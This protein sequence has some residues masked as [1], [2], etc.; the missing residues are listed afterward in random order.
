LPDQFNNTIPDFSRV[1]YRQGHVQLPSVPVRVVVEPSVQEDI[2]DT[3]RIQ[4]AIDQVASLPLE[5]FGEEGSAFRGAVLLKA[6]TYRVAGALVIHTAGIVLRGEG[7]D[8]AGTIIIATGAI[9]RDFIL[10][11]GQLTSESASV[12]VQEAKART[13]EMMPSNGYKG[14]KKSTHIR[15]GVFVPVGETYLQVESTAGFQVGDPIVVERPGS[16]E[17]INDIG[18]N[19]L[20]PRPD[21]NKASVQWQKGSFTFRFERTIVWIDQNLGVIELDI[22]MVMSFDPKYPPARVFE[23]VY[24]QPVISDVGIEN[25]RLVSAFDPSNAEDESHAWYAIVIDNTTNGWVSDVTTQHFV[26][27]IYAASW[28]RFITIQDCF[29][30]DPVSKPK[31]GGRR[32]Q[33]NL[34]GQMGLVKRCYTNNARHDFITLSRVCGPHE[35]W[36]MGTLYDN[37]ECNTI[38]VR[39]RLWKGTGQGWAG[40]YQVI[41]NCTAKLSKSCFQDAP[42]STNWVIGFKGGQVEV[43]EFRAQSTRLVATENQVEPRSL[44]W[45]QLIARMGG[46]AELKTML[47]ATKDFMGKAAPAGYIAGL[48]RGATGFTTRSDI[49]P[50]REGPTEADIARLQ[51]QAKR[52]AAE[53]GDDDD[54][55]YQDPDNETGLFNTAPYE[56]DDEEA[57]QIYDSIDA[58]LD[59]RRKAR[60]EARE[61]EMQEKLNKE[62]PKIQDQFADLK[63]G[64]NAVT[65]EEWENLPEVGNIAGK[66]RKKA[67]LRERLAPAPDS[68]IPRAQ[69]EMANTLDAQPNGLT[70][71]VPGTMTNFREIGEANKQVLGLRLDRMA[72]SASG[73]TTI[74]PKGYLTDLN[75]VIVKSEAEIGDLKKARLLLKSVITTNPKHAPGWIAAARLEEHAGKLADARQIIDKGCLECPK[76]EDIWLEAARLNNTENAKRILANAVKQ[77]PQSVKI[78]LQAVQLETTPKTQKTV[79]RRALDFVP[80]SVKLWK[81]AVEME[82]DPNN[83]RILL[84][85]AVELVPQS[86]DLWI[87]LARLETYENA[88]TVLNL[89]RT[90]IPTSHDIWIAAFNLQEANGQDV[91]RLVANAVKTL[92]MMESA[93]TRDQW[94]EEAEKCEKNGFINTCQAIV[95]ATVGM[96]VEEA[97]L[98]STWMEDAE[99]AVSRQSYG[100]ARAIYA[101]ALRTFPSKKSIWRRAAML[102]KLHGTRESLEELLVRAVRY[103]PQAE[104]LWLMGAKEKWLGGDVAGARAILDAAF[105]A[106]PNSEQIWLAAVKLEAENGEYGR[107]ELLLSKARQSADTVRVWMKSAVLE[108]QLGKTAEALELLDTALTKYSDAD[109]LWMIRG[110]IFMDRGDNQKARENFVKAL[111]NCSKSIPL[112]I[113]AANLEER[114]GLLIKARALLE[115]GRLLNPKTPELWLESVRLEL[116]GNNATMAKTLM[117]KALQECPSSGLLWSEA[118]WLETRAQRKGK[119]VDA[120]K[121]S[122][123]SAHVLI[124]AARLFWSDRQVEKARSWF[125]RA[126]K[127]DPD[128]G[129]AWAWH[130]KFEL[131][132]GSEPRKS[133]VVMRCKASEPRHGEYWQAV[134]K[135]LTN[136]GKSIENLLVLTA[137]SLPASTPA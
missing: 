110:Q 66:N 123:N 126:E 68:L 125:A 107:A 4:E 55:R 19:Q 92:S 15:A 108:R 56:A 25:L 29:V 20:P 119:I 7:Q 81:T 36:A 76:S 129:D 46:D 75:S 12:Q 135:D 112:W 41:Y 49:G 44:Y 90:K 38:N 94:L 80:N 109:K 131:E 111:K 61:K 106:N 74:D 57:D 87:A 59:E 67:T 85:R 130:F 79:I 113:L 50:A 30:L 88:R 93:L 48:G 128:L 96:G 134:T 82:D 72:D 132:H 11:N 114:V 1:G 77:I 89:A 120:L 100:T 70:T 95:L 97:D 99:S 43:P 62:R 104:F 121:K 133:D 53:D 136:S 34:S 42:G 64:L 32:Y 5:P 24:K 71:P 54:E 78:W 26:S 21:N 17:W 16:D 22:P 83:A 47:G 9:Q 28:S 103:C 101:H 58:K 8:E 102:E 65:V 91:E 124:T 2:D 52:K 40:A 122:E 137:A 60:R 10:V 116:R 117:A 33:F 14:T 69:G 73:Q 127:A 23:R 63:R 31:E 45:A 98:K 18:M 13:K 115:R 3:T 84:A 35:R 27:G 86:V 6:G 39:Q 51:E 105:E 118:V 37:I